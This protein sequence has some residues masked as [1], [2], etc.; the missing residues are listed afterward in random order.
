MRPQILL[1]L[2]LTTAAFPQA[3]PT[4]FLLEDTTI[5]AGTAGQFEPSQHQYCLAALKAGT[6]ACLVFSTAL[7]GDTNRY[8]TLL[9]IANFAHF[10]S[11]QYAASGLTVEE[12]H[13]QTGS[14]AAQTHQ[15]V[16][17]LEPELSFTHAPNNQRPLN[18]FL[19]YHLRPG[20][21]DAFLALV[22][23]NQL[24]AA[25]KAAVPAFEVF[26]TLVGAS[27]DR[28]FVVYRLDSYAQLDR[29]KEPDSGEWRDFASKD[30]LSSTSFVVR[31]R[32]E[33]SANPNDPTS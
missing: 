22:R 21:L 2:L 30:I 17:A 32:P 13:A 11:G 20:T 7:F 4:T 16:I 19:E 25:R 28:V 15:S 29:Y 23:S 10:D 33:I 6:P 18:L 27:P 8:L 9:P 12:D 31:Y 3:R 14:P 5:V 24:P 26:R 1:T